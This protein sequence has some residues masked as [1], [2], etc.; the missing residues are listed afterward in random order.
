MLEHPHTDMTLND[1]SVKTFQAALIS[2]LHA[3]FSSLG[4]PR[5]R[6]FMPRYLLIVYK[7]IYFSY[8]FF[9]FFGNYFLNLFFY[10][11]L[12]QN[13]D[14][15]AKTFIKTFMVLVGFSISNFKFG[16]KAELSRSKVTLTVYCE[17][18]DGCDC[19]Y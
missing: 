8:Y 15:I 11:I 1:K 13:P 9:F 6:V 7:V 12:D 5:A 16:L 2:Y 14:S 17:S 19:T 18:R 10:A 4:G 3:A